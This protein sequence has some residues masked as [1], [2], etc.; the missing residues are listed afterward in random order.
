MRIITL[1]TL[2]TAL[3]LAIFLVGCQPLTVP[4]KITSEEPAFAPEEFISSDFAR[5][6]AKLVLITKDQKASPEK[7]AEAH[8]RLAI[9]YL[10]PRNPHRDFRQAIE[11]LGN[12]LAAAPAQLD[13][14]AAASWATALRAGQEYQ[15]L[16]KKVANLDRENRQLRKET[17]ELGNTNANLQ[18]T[19]E[20]LKNLDLSLEKKRRNFR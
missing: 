19:I 15:E 7:K 2:S 12:F 6:T 3:I 1:K 13:R 17:E 9:L 4:S 5:E 16:E 8:R 10:N 18:T 20:K 11:E 14:A